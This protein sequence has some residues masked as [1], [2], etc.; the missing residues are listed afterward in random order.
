MGDEKPA[1]DSPTGEEGSA[2]GLVCP[3]CNCP[4]PGGDGLRL[5]PACGSSFRIEGPAL[6]STLDAI[7]VLGR[8]QLQERVGVGAFGAVWRAR[9]TQLGR[10]VAVKIPH[11]SLS[12][13]QG[14]LERLNRGARALD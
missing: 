1:S 13:A 10:L 12:G 4:V 5:C 6:E 9:D 2:G 8:F 11:P 7:G 14:A 3:H